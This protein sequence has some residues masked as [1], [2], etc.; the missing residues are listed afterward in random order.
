MRRLPRVNRTGAIN[1]E[2]WNLEQM[3]DEEVQSVIW[4]SNT[5]G[6]QNGNSNHSNRGYW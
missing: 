2:T 1:P 3:K 5:E 4:V 6:K